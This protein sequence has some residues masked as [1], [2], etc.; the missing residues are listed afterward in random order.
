MKSHQTIAVIQKKPRKS[1]SKSKSKKGRGNLA[2]NEEFAVVVRKK[3][4][5]RKT[6]KSKTRRKKAS[7]VSNV[8]NVSYGRAS[9]VIV[10]NHQRKTSKHTLHSTPKVVRAWSVLNVVG[11]ERGPTSTTNMYSTR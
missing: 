6:P 11:T 3:T 4:N 7:K 10:V 9:I 8:S 1:R 5:R 2:S